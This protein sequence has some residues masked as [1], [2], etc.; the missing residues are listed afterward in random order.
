MC[1]LLLDIRRREDIWQRG[2]RIR[3]NDCEILSVR[4][5]TMEPRCMEVRVI[6]AHLQQRY[7]VVCCPHIL[8]DFDNM[9]TVRGPENGTTSA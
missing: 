5:K 7:F 1:D 8:E 9:P 4:V 3:H 2:A 6:E